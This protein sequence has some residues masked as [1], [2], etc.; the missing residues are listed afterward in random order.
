MTWEPQR[1][2]RE[3]RQS[4][5]RFALALFMLIAITACYIVASPDLEKLRANDLKREAA[6]RKI[7][8]QQ[9]YHGR[10]VERGLRP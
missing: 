1:M 6:M 8:Q 9:R 3:Q 5:A 10:Q 4:N 2:R 7:D